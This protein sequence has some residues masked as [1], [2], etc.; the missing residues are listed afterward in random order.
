MPKKQK[1][2]FKSNTPQNLSPIMFAKIGAVVALIYSV[3]IPVFDVKYKIVGTMGHLFLDRHQSTDTFETF[4]FFLLPAPLLILAF[5]S[6]HKI[7]RQ[8]ERLPTWISF[9]SV[10]SVVIYFYLDFYFGLTYHFA[11]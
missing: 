3:F 7:P 6:L 8:A 1:Q 9:V 2:T 10:A 4:L 11:S 5:M